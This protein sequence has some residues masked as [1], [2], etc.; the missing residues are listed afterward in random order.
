MAQGD[1]WGKSNGN[2][3][4]K[5]VSSKPC[6]NVEHG[7]S[8]TAQMLPSDVH[9]SAADSQM[10]CHTHQVAWTRPFNGKT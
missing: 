7:L 1:K 9:T 5:W 2:R 6:T 10:T 8:S 3:E 4:V